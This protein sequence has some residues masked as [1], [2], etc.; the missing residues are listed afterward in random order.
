MGPIPH[1]MHQSASRRSWSARRASRSRITSRRSTITSATTSPTP[2][3]ASS[4]AR[5][6]AQVRKCLEN[7]N[8]GDNGIL[9]L[10]AGLPPEAGHRL[11]HPS[12]R[13][14][15]AG[16]ALHLRAAVGLGRVRH[17]PDPG[18]RPRCAVGSARQRHAEREAPRISISSSI[19]ST[20][21]ELRPELQGPSLPRAG[22]RGRHARGR[23]CRSLDRVREGG[24]RAALHGEGTDGR[25]RREVHRSKTTALTASSAC[26]EWARSMGSR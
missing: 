3:W 14:A 25:S 26:R 12:V 6:K 4:R 19:S 7:W 20:G 21:K 2:S 9:D 16:L 23:L 17:V 10:S 11:A 24:G 13:P 8:K 1:H 22:A 18:R 5:R 15:R